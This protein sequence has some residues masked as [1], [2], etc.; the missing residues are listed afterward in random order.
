MNAA[1]AENKW[2][3]GTMTMVSGQIRTTYYYLEHLRERG[4]RVRFSMVA[5]KNI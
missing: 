1:G 2:S 5:G 3:D 4:A